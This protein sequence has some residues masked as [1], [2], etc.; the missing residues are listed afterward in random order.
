MPGPTQLFGELWVQVSVP[1]CFV[2]KFDLLSVASESYCNIMIGCVC[3]ICP[4]NSL[5]HMDI[6]RPNLDLKYHCKGWRSL[7]LNPQ[8]PGL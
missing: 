1:N 2:I 4:I 5:G 6:W 7:G 3:V 8:I